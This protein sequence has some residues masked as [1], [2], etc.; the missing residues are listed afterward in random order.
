VARSAGDRW[1]LLGYAGLAGFVA[2]E[3]GLR[4]P[5]S[6][7]SL[8]ASRDD[9]GTTRQ[10]VAAYAV[11][12][13][14]APYLRRLPVGRLPAATAALGIAMQLAGLGLRAWSMQTLGASY[15]R[16]L[17][18][19]DEQTVVANGPY[20]C[21][22]HPGYLGSILTWSGF[23]V[24][25]GSLPVAATVTALLAVAYRERMRAEEALLERDLPGY[26]AY[27]RRTRRLVPG[28]W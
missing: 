3:A 11:A 22:R 4:R 12:A 17:R 9:R 10:I 21:V 25:S 5:G 13:G 19:H 7:A 26:R 23:A 8:E 20:A 14:A 2:I 1:F 24:A 16:T 6:S 27:A 15:S 28:V 18:T